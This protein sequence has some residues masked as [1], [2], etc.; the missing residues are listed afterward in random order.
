LDAINHFKN[1]TPEEVR[2]HKKLSEKIK[3]D[4]FEPVTKEGVYR[5]LE[6]EV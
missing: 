1:R 5:F 4:Y 2:T 6:L 3:K